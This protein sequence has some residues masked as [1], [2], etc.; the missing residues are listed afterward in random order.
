[1]TPDEQ[2]KLFAQY[3]EDQL[4]TAALQLMQRI[5]HEVVR[6]GDEA[7]H[8]DLPREIDDLSLGPG[9]N[10]ARRSSRTGLRN[11]MQV[12]DLGHGQVRGGLVWPGCG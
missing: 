12:V 1:M 4:F 5:D 11:R 10:L 2:L 8:G 6:R 7:V 9:T 3:D